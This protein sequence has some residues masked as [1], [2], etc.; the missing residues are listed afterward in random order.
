MNT[1]GSNIR[2]HSCSFVDFLLAIALMLLAIASRDAAILLL[3]GVGIVMLARWRDV[4]L[5]AKVMGAIIFV[6]VF[7]LAF[8]WRYPEKLGLAKLPAPAATSSQTIDPDDD[9]P[10]DTPS[11]GRF[12]LRFLHDVPRNWRLITDV[13]MLAGRW[14]CE[15]LAAPSWAVFASKSTP[16]RIASYILGYGVC[17]IFVVGVIQSIRARQY[18]ALMVLLYFGVIFL[19]WGA[20]VKP[21]YPAFIAPMI[22]LILGQ[23]IARL[24]S[25]LRTQ[26]SAL[27]MLIV[28][29]NLPPY[30]VE[31]YLRRQNTCD[32]YDV[33]RRGAYAPLIDIAGYLRKHSPPIQEISFNRAADRRVAH[34]LIGRPILIV[35]RKV[36]D[37]ADPAL[38]ELLNDCTTRYAVVYVEHPTPQMRWPR[39]HWPL[40]DAP[41]PVFYRLFENTPSGWSEVPVAPDRAHIR[42]VPPAP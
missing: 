8:A 15:S 23:G 16:A 7:G 3:P 27:F 32:F 41:P 29:A 19:M 14:I 24:Y 39:W 5:R 34:R 22:V 9:A 42:G 10:N 2:V 18:W 17:A 26:H 35:E 38:I 20:R 6:V 30:A 11:Q 4:P 21:R 37:W 25:G 28:A 36:A 1:N 12:K 31:L 33:A 13:P 40:G